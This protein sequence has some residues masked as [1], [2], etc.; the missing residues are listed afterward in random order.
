MAA[1][2][3]VV[4]AGGLGAALQDVPGDDGPGEGVVVVRPPAEVGGG[5]AGD[6]GGVGDPAGDDDIGPGAQTG[7]DTVAAEVGVGGEEPVGHGQAVAL[8][9]RDPD[10]HA[11]LARQLGDGPGECGRVEPPALATIFT[12]RSWASPRPSSSCCRKVVA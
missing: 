3:G 5:G 11:H 4:P 7:G 8:D 12:P 6:E 1:E 2:E 10:R 9:M